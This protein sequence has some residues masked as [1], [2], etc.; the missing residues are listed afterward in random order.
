MEIWNYVLKVKIL[1][2]YASRDFIILINN[3]GVQED[4]SMLTPRF[5][6]NFFFKN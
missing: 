3:L 5:F 4:F 2:L 6:Y 1:N